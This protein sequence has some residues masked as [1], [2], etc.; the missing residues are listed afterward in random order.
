MT[1]TIH[2][3]A[4]FAAGGGPGATLPTVDP[5]ILTDETAAVMALAYSWERS[6]W[7]IVDS[8]GQVY[9]EAANPADLADWLMD[10]AAEL[11]DMHERGELA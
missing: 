4:G 1:A 10:Y 7:V 11:G 3:E 6:T 5:V 2:Y 8:Q 9:A